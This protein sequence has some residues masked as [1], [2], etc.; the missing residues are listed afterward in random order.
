MSYI[1]P[2]L[3]LLLFSFSSFIL[4]AQEEETKPK[5]IEL[6][7]YIKDLQSVYFVN[8]ID[9]LTSVNLLHNRLNFKINF[10][11]HSNY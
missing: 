7:G 8:R 5:K 1:K 10:S 4:F 3:S 11:K 2:I 9:S 6:N